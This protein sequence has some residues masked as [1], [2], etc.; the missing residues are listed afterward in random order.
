MLELLTGHEHGSGTALL[1]GSPW[2]ALEGLW[3]AAL[4]LAAAG[5]GLG[6]WRA[7]HRSPWPRHR[8]LCW[9]LGLLAAAAALAGPLATAAHGSFTVHMVGHLLLGMIAPLL[10]VVAAPISLALRALP[11]GAA[12]SLTALLRSPPLRALTHPVVAAG[13]NGGGLWLIYTTPL[14]TLMHDSVLLH[15]L[16]HAHI[17][18]AGAL[19]TASLIGVDPQPHRASM[20]MRS[21]VL[22]G[23]IAAHA[24]LA[25]HLF[26]HPPLGV[27]AA[28]ARAGAQLMYY[29]GDAVDVLLIVLLF[30]G[31]YRAT[32]PYR[33]RAPGPAAAAPGVR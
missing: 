13:L 18:T 10:L 1:P 26:A 9:Y 6:L 7:R 5:Y 28:D 20:G 14:F 19:M 31:W 33:P 21:V 2:A 30:A 3:L 32:R 29:G 16:V 23:F 25:K 11:A 4:L 8:T 27:E 22:I 24:I 17:L 15:G 12:R